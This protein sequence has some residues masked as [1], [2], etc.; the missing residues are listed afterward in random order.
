[1]YFD[2]KSVT[3]GQHRFKIGRV[4]K[5]DFISACPLET[6][7]NKMLLA[8]AA[9][10]SLFQSLI[11][12]GT[13]II[14]ME[15]AEETQKNISVRPGQLTPQLARHS[16]SVH[17]SLPT[18]FQGG[19]AMHPLDC[20]K[21]YSSSQLLAAFASRCG[22]QKPEEKAA[23]ESSP[24]H[25]QPFWNH[26]QPAGQPDFAT[27]LPRSGPVNFQGELPLHPLCFRFPTVLPSSCGERNPEQAATREEGIT[28]VNSKLQTQ[29]AWL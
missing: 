18:Y 17:S 26:I 25:C 16:L 28:K 5:F 24:S 10:L 20:Y 22:K 14:K 15:Q 2:R 19:S 11:E 27:H 21:P 4:C 7:V 3:I 6:C 13:R 8:L 1:M 23:R 9:L 12:N 29:F